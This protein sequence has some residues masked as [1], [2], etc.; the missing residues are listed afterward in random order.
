MAQDVHVRIAAVLHIA[1]GV[2]FLL[3]LAV[4][5]PLVAAFGALGP[6]YGVDADLAAIVGGVGILIVSIV[7]LLSIT[8]IVGAILLLRGSKAGHAIVLGFSVFSL[9]NIPIGTVA[10]I[11]CLWALLHEPLKSAPAAVA[12]SAPASSQPDPTGV[13]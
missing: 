3:A 10:G 11:Y 8:E 5:G 2:L 7:A 9:L 1:T 6:S 4:I 13:S 12:A